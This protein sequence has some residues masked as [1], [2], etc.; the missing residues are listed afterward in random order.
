MTIRI[1]T[2]MCRAI[3][4]YSFNKKP[5]V[6]WEAPGFAVLSPFRPDLGPPNIECPVKNDEDRN[7]QED[8]KPRMHSTTFEWVLT[9]AFRSLYS[10]LRSAVKGFGAS[11]VKFHKGL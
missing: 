8:A 4:R 10:E 3:V 2:S 1:R 11:L 7:N 6:C 5:P 9:L